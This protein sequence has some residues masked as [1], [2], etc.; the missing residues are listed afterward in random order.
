M[1]VVS[2]EVEGRDPEID[3]VRAPRVARRAALP[4]AERRTDEVE[5]RVRRVLGVREERR[6]VEVAVSVRAL[7]FEVERG[8]PVVVPARD[9][10][11]SR[12]RGLAGGFAV[13]PRAD[14]G[15]VH[16][17]V[18]ELPEEGEED[19][20]VD[21]VA[22]AIEI[23][24]R[25]QGRAISRHV[26]LRPEREDGPE[27][28]AAAPF[29]V[30][31]A[32]EIAVGLLS[33]ALFDV[34]LGVRPDLLLHGG[35]D[36][37]RVLRERGLLGLELVRVPPRRRRRGSPGLLERACS[38]ACRPA[39]GRRSLSPCRPCQVGPY[40]AAQSPPARAR[41]TSP[42]ASTRGRRSSRCSG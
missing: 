2:V 39:V 36:L 14:D 19:V 35:R 8:E 29:A 5:A 32:V 23:E 9:R 12:R 17:A 15:G 25:D 3:L 10:R 30:V 27:P 28:I 42:R 16:R 41:W 13:H 4:L 34:A 7:A 20:G 26:A 24:G 38:G 18:A 37:G 21:L 11:P 6:D 22:P 33:A 1:L 31:E 40:R